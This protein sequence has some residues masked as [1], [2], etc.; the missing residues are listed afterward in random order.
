[1]STNRIRK[2]G[3][4]LAKSDIKSQLGDPLPLPYKLDLSPVSNEDEEETAVEPQPL[5][6]H[7]RGKSLDSSIKLRSQAIPMIFNSRG[8][9]EGSDIDRSDQSIVINKPRPISIRNNWLALRRHSGVRT[10]SGSKSISSIEAIEAKLAEFKRLIQESGD[11]PNLEVL[12]QMDHLL[13]NLI[14]EERT[15][16]HAEDISI[17]ESVGEEKEL[18]LMEELERLQKL[19]KE[20]VAKNE[21]QV[22]QKWVWLF[23][24][25][26]V[27][28][29]LLVVLSLMYSELHYEYCYYFC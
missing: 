29:P 20:I 5:Y 23:I 15:R 13:Q 21:L 7:K 18:D 10:N 27:L 24:A 1:M 16:D 26:F 3:P 12:D 28:V 6:G 14:E 9:S 2:R 25:I 4:A 22:D 8:L 19:K 17:T 11:E